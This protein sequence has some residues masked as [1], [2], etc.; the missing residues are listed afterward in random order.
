[1]KRV[2]E[3]L[4][5][6][7]AGSITWVHIEWTLSWGQNGCQF[8]LTARSYVGQPDLILPFDYWPNPK[9][10]FETIMKPIQQSIAMIFQEFLF[11]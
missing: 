10:K 3:E 9:Q 2:C 8:A 7:V 4:L 6:T 11:R 1:M 5:F